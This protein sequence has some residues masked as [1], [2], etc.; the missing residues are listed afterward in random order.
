[1][2]QSKNQLRRARKKIQK[3]EAASE[4]IEDA[5]QEQQIHQNSVS[6]TSK[7]PSAPADGPSPEDN[8]PL[9]EM[10]KGIVSKF[11]ETAG[12]TATT[13]D[14][15]KPEVYYDDADDIPD[16]ENEQEPRISKKK[17][18]EM[19]KLSVAEL[20]AMV[21]KPEIVEWTDT[22]AT[23]PRLLIQ[24]KAHRNVVPVPL[25][26]SLKREYLSS[27]RGV[28]KAPF[29][30]PK[31]IQE[32]G[33]AEM[34]DA[35]LDKQD[36]SS[37]KQKQRERVQPKMGRLDIDYQKLYEAFFRF[38]TKPELTRYGEIYYE[39]KEYET[40]LKHLRP[41][42]LS[43]ELK[44]ALNMPPGAPPPWLINQQRYGPPPSYPALKVP[45][46]NAPP[47]PGA[48][49]GYHPGGYGKPPVDEHNRPL[50]GGDIFGVLQ[51]Q[52]ND[53]QGEPIEKDLWGE[54][55]ASEESEEESEED[56]DEEEDTDE[57]EA[58]AETHSPSGLDT[59][60]GMAS[61]APSEF[62]GTES[63]AGEFDV[64]KH[65]RGTETEETVHPRSAYQVIPEKQTSVQGFFGGDRAYDLSTSSGKPPL[66]GV[67]DQT[68]K[69]K[70]PGDVDVSVDL[71]A[72]QAGDGLSK[73]SL[74]NMYDVQRQ[75]QNQPQ[76]GFQEDLS[77]M[78]AQESRKRLR[79]EE[80]RRG[81]H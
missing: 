47:P 73:E 31:F 8:D 80:E 59:P 58:E 74:Q 77:D 78:I 4:A 1:M 33:I 72:I 65:H 26:W 56:E 42:E 81:K 60:S 22:S 49:W 62:V 11:D 54:L 23:D 52:Q 55:Q 13:K 3:A 14:V 67:D 41:G 46:L 35:A 21:H 66:L 2:K 50:Y 30:L 17:R 71:D 43:D 39:G 9:W 63:V 38:Q 25:H 5:P 10:Y 69:R 44:E 76:W 20:K 51:P 34:R 16:E 24:I 12:E 7:V 79:K 70:K 36:Q 37:L 48:M 40:N 64:R 29:A 15:E 57:E 18:K 6:N 53:Q 75:Q 19:N 27:K 32:T 28:E 45:G 68:R 61:A